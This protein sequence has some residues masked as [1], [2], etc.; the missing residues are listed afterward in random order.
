MQT[1]TPLEFIKHKLF[2]VQKKQNYTDLISGTYLSLSIIL[3]ISL[4][5]IT[6][7]ILF[8]L[9]KTARTIMVIIFIATSTIAFYWYVLRNLLKL[10]GIIESYTAVELAK[11]VGKSYPNIQD[12]LLN[13]LQLGEN[14]PTISKI[15]SEELINESLR[16]F[17]QEIES[18]DFTGIVDTSRIRKTRKFSIIICSLF[19]LLY[20][21]FP[22]SFSNS[23]YRLTN[24]NQEFLRP[25]DF[26]FQISPGNKVIVKGENVEVLIKAIPREGTVFNKV[27]K[28][29]L[30]IRQEP[31]ENFEEIK[32]R[33]D[34]NNV[35][36]TTLFNIRNPIEYFAK[37]SK[38]ESD[39]Y[40]LTVLDRPVI[41]A[42]RIKLEYPNYTKLPPKTLDDFIGD[43]RALAGTKIIINGLASKELKSASLKFGNNISI[44]MEIDGEKFRASF[45]LTSDNT[46]H[47]ELVDK[48]ELTN[49]DPVTYKLKVI[50]DEYPSVSILQPGK[51]IDVAGNESLPVLIE[52][53]DD[54]GFTKLQLAHRLV[55][56]R[57][58][59]PHKEY[60]YIQIPFSAQTGEKVEIRYLWNLK[61]LNLVPE[62]VLEYYAEIFD[63]DII[64]GPKSARS[65][66]YL[67]RLP[68]IE[69]V[70]ADIDKEHEQTLENLKESYEYARELKQEIESIKRELKKDKDPDWQTQKKAQEMAKRYEE[71]QKKLDDA[72]KR[73]DNIIQK[74]QQQTVL[75]QETLEKYLELQQLLEQIN[76]DELQNLLNQLQQ[77]MP[78]ISKEQLQQMMEKITF[79]EEL[80]RQSIERTIDLLKRIQIEYKLD[81]LRKR[82]S[83]LEKAQK[84]LAEETAKSPSDPQKQNELA[85]RQS[86]L[87]KM[88]KALEK[89]AQELVQRMEEFF[90]EMPVEELRKSLEQLRQNNLNEQMQNTSQ[91]MQAGNMQQAQQIQQNTIQMLQSFS[92]KIDAIQQQMLQQQAQFIINQLRKTINDLLEVSKKQEDLKNQSRS[93]P[94]N[95]PQLRQNAQDQLKTINDLNNV[96]KNLIELSK[97]SFAITPEIA[98]NINEALKHMNEAMIALDIRNG[99]YASQEQEQAMSAL[100]RA[101]ISVQNTLQSMM[102]G[103]G[104]GIGSLMQQLKMMADRQMAINIQTQQIQTMSQEQAAEAARLAR[105]QS[106]IQKSLEELNREAQ[107][108]AER[109]RILGDLQKIVDDMK[110]VVKGLEENKI[111]SETL[112]KQERIL[113]RL[114]DASK[115]IHERDYEK[116]RKAETGKPVYQQS[117]AELTPDV[118]EGRN[119][120]REEILKSIEQGYTKDYQELIRKY[121]E[122][123]EKE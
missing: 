70:F 95:S 86:D 113:S 100:N 66:T 21:F 109:Q 29:S 19:I 114:L 120:L 10:Y 77:R 108:S 104:T 98:R 44:P 68:S 15:Y 14:L 41:R 12:R 83:E 69:E 7:D 94:A 31:Q 115:S 25:A 57:Y 122:Q 84:E 71:L 101:A 56:S 11:Q 51:D 30:F 46:Y 73:I 88:E 49:L 107:Q 67:L 97:K 112:R 85:K 75:S 59:K 22:S 17:A 78:S 82:A 89:E 40:Y 45:T 105:E 90:A 118:M 63:N 28:I 81:E 72:Q 42:F 2:T 16:T 96:V 61:N 32:L 5:F 35:F 87:A 6:I 65:Q 3:L 48:Q 55:K 54:F 58:E 9:N 103:G 36:R 1:K 34:S 106:A 79:S 27:E 121:F 111:N 91:L 110:E 26:T 47:V 93:A 8:Q 119:K 24:F 102:Q 33:Y 62:D 117:P 50:Q 13:A 23:L 37:I 4:T 38:D 53:K 99:I 116:R 92:Q 80:F 43:V 60:T 18:L 74:S 20:I 64:K 123:L 76:S 52:A 39:H